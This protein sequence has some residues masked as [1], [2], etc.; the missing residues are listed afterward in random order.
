MKKD[1]CKAVDW[2]TKA[3]NSGHR[4]AHRELGMIYAYGRPEQSF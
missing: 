1:V 3:A 2:L 4:R